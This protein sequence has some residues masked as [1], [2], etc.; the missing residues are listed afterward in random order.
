MS[1]KKGADGV[2]GQFYPFQHFNRI[3]DHFRQV[4]PVVN[5][6]DAVPGMIASDA[7]DNKL[8]HFTGDSD[9]ADEVLQA[10]GSIDTIPLF[11]GIDLWAGIDHHIITA[12]TEAGL[13]GRLTIGL[14]ETARTMVVCDYGDIDSD[15]GLVIANE[16]T[17][18]VMGALGVKEI[19]TPIAS[20]NYGKFYTKNDNDPYFQDG[21]GNEHKIAVVESH[22][23]Y[24]EMYTYNNAVALVID[25]AD[26][27]HGRINVSEGS[28]CGE[29]TFHAGFKQAITVWADGPG[30]DVTATSAGIQAAGLAVGDFITITGTT[31]YNGIYEVQAVDV[32][33]FDITHSWDGN[34]AAGTITL[35]AHYHV[36]EAICAGL[37]KITSNMS[38]T[39]AGNSKEYDTCVFVNA[40]PQTRIFATHKTKNAGDYDTV[41]FDGFM[42]LANGDVI[43]LGI[44]GKT[45]A[46]NLT[47][48]HANL[49]M[50]F[51]Q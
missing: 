49:A 14:D 11:L 24:A 36:D 2:R 34:D 17:L 16:P 10:I 37:W 30:G 9:I 45:D 5:L 41:A 38:L 50:I 47:V 26:T 1:L 46:T 27:W 20:P 18:Y 40:T 51:V 29:M 35:P 21:A 48:K 42:T 39:P 8:W 15:F 19:T 32:N 4:D 33:T 3:K 44:M 43:W 28:N 6:T 25:E 7:F 22:F 31:N 13:G 12:I 23:H